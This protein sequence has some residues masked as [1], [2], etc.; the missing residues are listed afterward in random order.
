ME[1]DDFLDKYYLPKLNQDQVSNLTGSITNKEVEAA[2]QSFPAK[3]SLGPDCFSVQF[4]HT[5]KE[6]LIPIFVE[7]GFLLL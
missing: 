3:I 4:Y 2:I 1:M 5:F 6:E 7:N